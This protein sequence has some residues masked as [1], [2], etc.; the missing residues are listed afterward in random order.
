MDRA[1]FP[2]CYV[3]QPHFHIWKIKIRGE[4]NF[5]CSLI[6]EYKAMHTL[7]HTQKYSHDMVYL[8]SIF[9]LNVSLYPRYIIYKI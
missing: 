8:L 3:S 6:F 9:I 5:L 1:L 4:M 2:I 7:K